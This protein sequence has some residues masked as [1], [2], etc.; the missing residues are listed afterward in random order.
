MKSKSFNSIKRYISNFYY[1]IIDVGITFNHGKE[2]S[3]G[4]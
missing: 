1:N 4:D 2:D 3:F